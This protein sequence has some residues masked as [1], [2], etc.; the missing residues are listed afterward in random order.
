LIWHWHACEETEHKAVA[1]DVFMRAYPYG[2]LSWFHKAVGQVLA[3]FLLWSLVWMAFL[4]MVITD[5]TVFNLKQWYVLTML[6]WGRRYDGGTV[7]IFRLSALPWFDFFSPSFHPWQ[8]GHDN[9]EKLKE[10]PE[11]EE[12]IKDLM[13]ENDEDT[14][15]YDKR[16]NS[17]SEKD[18]KKTEKE[19]KGKKG[20]DLEQSKEGDK[21]D[22]SVRDKDEN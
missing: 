4:G 6:L 8:P 17:D 2:F 20:E 13:E 14:E 15:D 5:G 21:I 11:L 1:Y 16:V 19:Q 12:K 3:T 9:S 7:G 22:K 10:M 18:G